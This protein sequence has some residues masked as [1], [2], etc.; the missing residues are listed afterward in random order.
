[1]RAIVD[2][3][4]GMFVVGSVANGAGRNGNQEAVIYDIASGSKQRYTLKT[5]L[6]PDDHNTSGFI[7]RPDGKYTAMWSTHR[8]TCISYYGV[9]DGSKWS[10]KEYDWT[11]NGCPWDTNLSPPP[12]PPHKITYANVY[13]LSAEDKVFSAVRSISTS[14]GV[15]VSTDYGDNWKL[16]GRLTSTMT[17]GYVAGYFKYWGNGVD[18]IDFVGTEA[19]PRDNNNNLWHGY[20]KGGKLYNTTDKVIDDNAGDTNAQDVSKFTQVFAA[21]TMLK[22]VPIYRLWNHDIMRYADGTIVITGQGRIANVQGEDNPDKRMIYLRWNGSQ[23]KASY[24]VKAGP[25]LYADEQDYT[26]VSAIHPENPNVIF[27]STTIDP[28]DDMTDLKKHEIFM[29]VTCDEGATWK[30]APLTEKSTVDNIRPIVPKW[31]ASH[32]LLLWLK[33]TYTSAQIYTMQV[34]GTTAL[35]LVQ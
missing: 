29:G 6:N 8:D 34:V 1:V 19:H 27:V 14:P 20:Y 28:R 33:G 25:K 26:G 7:V 21:G 24:L 31:D 12:N 35:P 32:T 2:V 3:K 5:G 18:R 10:S 22:G 11:S 13:Y 16:Y 9:F 30:W 15:L 23:W 4:G 17:V